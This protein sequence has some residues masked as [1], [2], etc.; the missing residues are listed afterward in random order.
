MNRDAPMDDLIAY[1][2]EQALDAL[3]QAELLYDNNHEINKKINV[4]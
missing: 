4:L 3:E 2:L 1:R